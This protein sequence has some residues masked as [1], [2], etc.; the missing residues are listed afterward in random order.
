MFP[1]T[2]K[3]TETGESVQDILT[4]AAWLRTRRDLSGDIDLVGL[5]KGGV[6]S[7]FAAAIDGGFAKLVVDAAG[8]N[9]DDDTA[10]V[11]DYYVPCIRSVGDVDTAAVL[12]AHHPLLLID[13]PAAFTDG[14]T[15]LP[16]SSAQDH[17]PA[18]DGDKGPNTGGM[19]AYSPAPVVTPALEKEIFDTVL[20][21]AVDGMR[22]R[23]TPYKGVLY[24]GLMICRDGR[25]RVVEFNCRFGDPETQPLLMR[26]KTDLA[27]VT[28]AIVEGRLHEL[29][30]EWD[31]DPAVCVVLASGGY[32]GSY[33]KGKVI[34]GLDQV[35]QPGTVVFHAGTA[36]KEGQVVTSGGRVLGVTSRA[37]KLADAI[38]QAYAA[39]ETIQFEGV[40]F[41]RDIGKKA[42]DREN[43]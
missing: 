25:P 4:A 37:P 11:K 14:V 13:A 17:K 16:M 30:L 24:A 3:P 7:L 21:R 26:L 5:G 2:F 40:F 28:E 34:S 29:K 36:E 32:P 43:G 18:Y 27:D 20:Q 33:E 1:D 15:V 42:L 19:G 41:R 8:F 12:I 39:C 6:W 23:G 22:K 9:P 31:S 38:R 10:W 35:H